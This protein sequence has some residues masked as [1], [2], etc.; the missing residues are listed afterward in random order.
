MLSESVG[1]CVPPS[2][3]SSEEEEE[4]GKKCE[5]DKVKLGER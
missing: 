3:Y 4:K 1:E 2:L 5:E